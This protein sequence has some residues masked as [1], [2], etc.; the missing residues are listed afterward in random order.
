MPQRQLGTVLDMQCQSSPGVNTD[1]HFKH[2]TIDGSV[3][4]T[5]QTFRI[6]GNHSSH[7]LLNMPYC[8]GLNEKSPKRHLH[9]NAW[10]LGGGCLRRLFKKV[11]DV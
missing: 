5:V 9:L 2:F 7:C 3:L 10:F 11:V 8:D 1:L 4:G 6:Q